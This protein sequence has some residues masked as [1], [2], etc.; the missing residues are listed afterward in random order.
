LR[1]RIFVKTRSGV[2]S[3]NGGIPVMNS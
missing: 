1:L 2:L 3:L